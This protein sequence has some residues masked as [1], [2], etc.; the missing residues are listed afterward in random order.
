MGKKNESDPDYYKLVFDILLSL[1][2]Y[3]QFQ[4]EY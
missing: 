4:D 3:F 1:G 2:E